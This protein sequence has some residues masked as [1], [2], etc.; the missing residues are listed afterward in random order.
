MFT[1]VLI[2][3]TDDK[4]NSTGERVLVIEDE[5]FWY[6]QLEDIFSRKIIMNF[7][8]RETESLITIDLLGTKFVGYDSI[9]DMMEFMEVREFE[10]LYIESE[11]EITV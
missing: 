3:L 1:P 8:K 6:E 2:K 4:T 9:D 5:D 10:N 7:E 11:E